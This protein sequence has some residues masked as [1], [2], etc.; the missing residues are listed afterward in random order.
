MPDPITLLRVGVPGQSGANVTAAEK[1]TYVTTSAANVFTAAQE[2]R[3]SS[4]AALIAS[5]GALTTDRTLVLDTTGKEVELWNGAKLRVFSDAGT[6][7]VAALDGAT[8]NMQIDGVFTV[9]G[10]RV[11][12]DLSVWSFFIDG[13]GSAITT[14]VKGWVK[15]PFAYKVTAWEITADVSGSAVV[16]F[17]SDSYANFPPTVADTITT[18]EKPTLAAV[19]KNTD[20]SLNVGAGWTLTNGNYLMWNVDSAATVTKVLI[21]FSG[22]RL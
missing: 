15:I 16:D 14:G 22:V 19:Q 9:S 8:G 2:V 7:E 18:S 17:W 20:T 4:T 6:T 5:S 11:V 12:G 21:A 13:G 10:G 1:A 3:V